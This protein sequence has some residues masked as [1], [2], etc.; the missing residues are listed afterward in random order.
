[1]SAALSVFFVV[2]GLLAG[3]TGRTLALYLSAKYNR[4]SILVFMLCAILVLSVLLL[5]FETASKELD[6]QLHAFC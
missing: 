1:V 4:V 5:I 2:V 6:F 3:G